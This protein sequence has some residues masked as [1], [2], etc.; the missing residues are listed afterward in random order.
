MDEMKKMMALQK[1]AQEVQDKLASIH[2]EA[3]EENYTVIINGK[4][5]PIDILENGKSMPLLVKALTKALKKSQQ[6]AADEMKGVM[7]SLGLPGM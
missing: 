6:I 2:I 4:Q 3:D 7:G 1:K 5:E